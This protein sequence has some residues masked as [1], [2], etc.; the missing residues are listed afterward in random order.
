MTQYVNFFTRIHVHTPDLV[1]TPTNYCRVSNVMCSSCISDHFGII[2]N[3]ESEN[4]TDT[5]PKKIHFCQYH[6]INKPKLF[7]DIKNTDFVCSPANEPM[8]LYQQYIDY[9]T[10]VMDSHAPLITKTLKHP[11]PVWITDDHRQEPWKH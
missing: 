7:N 3:I 1:I 4:T 2:L 6:N 10:K 8:L 5:T 11:T 9:I